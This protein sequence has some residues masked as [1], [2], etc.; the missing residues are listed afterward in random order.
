MWFGK[1]LSGIYFSQPL[2]S[3]LLVERLVG[4]LGVGAEGANAA[5]SGC[6]G[7][8]T[9]ALLLIL[10]REPGQVTSPPGF[11]SPSS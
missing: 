6:L 11:Q 5:I 3:T 8:R 9:Q 7:I 1:Q 10:A 2:E 4:G